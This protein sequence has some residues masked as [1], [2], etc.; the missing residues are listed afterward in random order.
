MAAPTQGTGIFFDG[1]SAHRRTVAVTLEA[2]ALSVAAADG[3]ALARWPY[4][5]VQRVPAAQH[6]LRL[7][8]I[9]SGS[10]AR[11]A[12]PDQVFGAAVEDR[13]GVPDAQ[14]DKREQHRRHRVVEWTVAAVAALLF[15]GI[16]GMPSLAE[17][18]LPFV[19]AS[20]EQSLGDAIDRRAVAGFRGPGSFACGLNGAEKPGQAAF[21]KL[22]GKLEAAAALPVKLHPVV[23]R[24]LY[25]INA[26]AV[27]GGYVFVL[28]G[29]V[30][31]VDT[32]EEL[33]G[34]LAHELG[35]VAHR[36]AMRSFL[37]QA[38]VSF[39]ISAVLG[40]VF[41]T[42]VGAFTQVSDVLSAQ[43]TRTEEAAADAYSTQLLRKMGQNPQAIALIF[44][45]WI[46][47]GRRAPPR[48]FDD[49]PSN[50][51]RLDTILATPKGEVTSGPLLTEEEWTALKH[52]CVPIPGVGGV[53]GNAA[54][55]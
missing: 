36:D 49:H 37:H 44:D 46:R 4:P 27:P 43:H 26:M 8:L 30:D 42:G 14:F 12:I 16:V 50:Q 11:L 15:L 53:G 18:L 22:M 5:Q 38:G 25:T 39:I 29:I 45:H 17:A 32:P 7:G 31:Y 1:A 21:L 28:Y 23:V 9:D 10:S 13:L 51:Q 48:L 55:K 41:S 19:P 6:H 52:I 35:H 2:D 47:D 24:D 3:T 54:A 40:D 20:V 34:V 33:A